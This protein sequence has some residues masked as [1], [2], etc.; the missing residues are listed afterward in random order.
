LSLLF[1][2]CFAMASNLCP[3][4]PSWLSPLHCLKLVNY[5]L[6]CAC[7]P[8]SLAIS[9]SFDNAQWLGLVP[10]SSLSFHSLKW[11]LS[12]FIQLLY[13]HY[14]L[15]STKP[16]HIGRLPSWYGANGSIP[17]FIRQ[18]IKCLI[19]LTDALCLHMFIHEEE[20]NNSLSAVNACSN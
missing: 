5:N 12:E 8:C 6:R 15:I 20:K 13:Q 9:A 3:L 18:P 19:D 16:N 2:F 1:C 11:R 4:Q 7:P 14:S 17:L 10:L